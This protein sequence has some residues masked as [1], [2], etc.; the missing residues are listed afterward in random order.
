MFLHTPEDEAKPVKY[1]R[2]AQ[3]LFEQLQSEG[4]EGGCDAVRRYVG[5]WRKE[6]GKAPAKAFI[7]LEYDPGDAFQFDWNYEDVELGGVPVED[8]IAQFR[9]CHS[10]MPF[11]IAYPV[12]RPCFP[13]GFAVPVT[14]W[15]LWLAG[16]AAPA[17]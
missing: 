5:A 15:S 7:P 3:I 17:P 4:Y 13:A 9:L 16:F 8:K 10:R 12:A 14:H 1:R 11:C 6:Q 2:R